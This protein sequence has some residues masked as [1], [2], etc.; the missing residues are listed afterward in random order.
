MNEY[1]KSDGFYKL[2]G[3]EG[4]VRMMSNKLPNA[5]FMCIFACCRQTYDWDKMK[6]F[7][8]ADELHL[9]QQDKW[10]KLEQ[11]GIDA[12]QAE[13]ESRGLGIGSEGVFKH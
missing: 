10:E 1:S 2:Y 8:N 7:Y 12:E 11:S 6:G 5:Y 9:E 3:A 13:S 4:S